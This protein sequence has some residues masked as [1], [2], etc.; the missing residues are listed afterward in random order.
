MATKAE[1]KKFMF[2]NWEDHLDDANCLNKTDLAE[3]AATH[4]GDNT[5]DDEIAEEYFEIAAE[6]DERLQKDGLVNS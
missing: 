4:F 5:E 6:V 2:A 3:D 1:I